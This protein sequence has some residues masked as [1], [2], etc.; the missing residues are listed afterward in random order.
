MGKKW[1]DWEQGED[2]DMVS[3]SNGGGLFLKLQQGNRYKIRLVGK[4]LHYYQFWEPIVV[5]SPY[6]DDDG[7]VICPLCQAGFTPKDRFSIWVIDRED[8]KLKIMDF[9]PSLFNSFREWHKATNEDPG[10]R[11]GPDFSIKVEA[12]SGK[13]KYVKYS[14]TSIAPAPFTEEEIKQIK[15]GK[16]KERMNEVR[17]DD[18]PDDIRQKMVDAGIV[19]AS[20]AEKKPSRVVSDEKKTEK[21]EE[22]E[23]VEA[24]GSD[25]L[26]SELEF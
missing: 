17:K 4:A 2:E 8:G 3:S 9:P 5:R 25:S 12:P 22:P 14:A 20:T 26:G 21:A 1:L 7:T 13:Q 24:S 23:K 16:L 18:S 15:D 11:N 6:K 19:R 10:G